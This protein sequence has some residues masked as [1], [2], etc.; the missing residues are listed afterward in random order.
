MEQKDRRG[1][2]GYVAGVKSRLIEFTNDMTLGVV[3][4]TGEDTFCE[5]W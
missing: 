3:R 2:M 1:Q 4:N 5:Y